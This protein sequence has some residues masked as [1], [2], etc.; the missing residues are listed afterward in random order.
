MNSKEKLYLGVDLGS[1]SVKLSLLGQEGSV[2]YHDYLRSKGQPILVFLKLLEKLH[3]KFNLS[4]VSKVAVT[5]SGGRKIASALESP[6]YNE[7]LT[8]YKATQKLY[9]QAR[10]IVD[11]GG[12]DSKLILLKKDK[13]TNDLYIKDFAMNAICAAGTGSFLDQQAK[14]LGVNIEGEFGS[15]AL[16]SKD[17]PQIAGRCSVFA[18]TD[19]IHLQQEAAPDHDI[20]AGLCFALARSFKNT[21]ARGKDFNKPTSFSG[22]VAANQGMVRALRE[23]LN[24]SQAELFV[25][26]Y[27]QCMGAIG[28]ALLAIENKNEDWAFKG[29]EKIKADLFC[30]KKEISWLGGLPKNKKVVPGCSLKSN[31]NSSS[32]SNSKQG[33]L[34]IDVGSISTNLVVISNDGEVLAKQYL[35][36]A[37]RPLRAVQAGLKK[38]YDQIKDSIKICGVG[39]TGSGRYLTGDFVGADQTRNEITAQATA[40]CFIDPQVDT[41][42]EIG[43][44]D[45]KYISLHNGAV[46]D[47]RMNKVCAAGTGSFLEEQAQKLGVNIK[48]EFGQKAFQANQACSLGER[49]TVF[50]ESNLVKAQQQGAGIDELTAGLSYSIV[51][52]YLN[53][54]VEDRKIGQ[55]IF[56]QGGVAYNQAV[57]SAFE[58][59]LSRKITIPPNHEVTGAIGAALLAKN[60]KK[61][62]TN[63]KGFTE[64]INSQYKLHSFECPE[65]PNHCKVKEVKLSSNDSLYYGSRCDKF[66]LNKRKKTKEK[67]LDLFKEREKRL[68]A[69]H[70]K[71]ALQ[72]K[73]K[74]NLK[75]GVPLAMISHELLPLWSTFF[76]ELGIEVVLSD[77]TNKKIIQDGIERV[78]SETCFPVKAAHGHIINLIDKKVDAIFVP[79]LINMP[80]YYPKI[81]ES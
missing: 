34:G 13:K 62:K 80:N 1:V 32:A 49:C 40:A 23:T 35:M 28:A 66:E 69:N 76:G 60:E 4:V 5:G 41:I 11:I 81:R 45:S 7:I 39:T 55:K 19:M 25:P 31:L 47:F 24:L 21:V 68:L 3:L 64:I 53:R 65:C 37:G 43:G 79:T 20:A 33:F 48:N 2:V 71:Y 16:K 15:L 50:M 46:V 73:T 26:K 10:S 67:S 27:H 38:I 14:R 77:K 36:T 63:F 58:E 54:V 72:K 51:S 78:G 61:G 30:L 52:N 57:I 12:Q 42:F 6:F 9:P 17:P 56:F 74:K 18:K 70:R 44:Q 75:V 29:L 59:V 22:G 8:Q